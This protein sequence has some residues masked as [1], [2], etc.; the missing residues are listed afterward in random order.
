MGFHTDFEVNG[1]GKIR[2]SVWTLFTEFQKRFII[3]IVSKL[4]PLGR[5][6]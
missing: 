3:K 5:V 4:F 6:F 2:F 1:K